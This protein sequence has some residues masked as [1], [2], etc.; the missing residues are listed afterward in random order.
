MV[1]LMSA[2][3]HVAGSDAPGLNSPVC[4]QLALNHVFGSHRGVR[5]QRYRDGGLS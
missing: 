3:R 4:V 2:A 5:K 1:C